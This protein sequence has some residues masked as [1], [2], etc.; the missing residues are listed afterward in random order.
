MEMRVRGQ[1]GPINARG[2]EQLGHTRLS[3]R[4]TV[5]GDYTVHL[6]SHLLLPPSSFVS[7]PPL[8]PRVLRHRRSA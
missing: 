8:P 5:M 7:F 6:P 2:E 1:S 3:D 4:V